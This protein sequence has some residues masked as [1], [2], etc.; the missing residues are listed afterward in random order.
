MSNAGR[1]KIHG[2]IISDP[3]FY[4]VAYPCIP[5]KEVRIDF[6]VSEKTLP[7]R[8][9]CTAKGYQSHAGMFVDAKVNEWSVYVCVLT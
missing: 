4:I 9:L 1:E 3:L 7:G 5:R 6:P 2:L 8:R